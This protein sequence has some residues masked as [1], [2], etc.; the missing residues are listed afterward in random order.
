MI[1]IVHSQRDVGIALFAGS[2]AGSMAS[3]SAGGHVQ[4][5]PPSPPGHD[6]RTSSIQALRM[7]AKEHVESITKG[8]QMV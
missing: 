1:A 6:P 7:R 4:P 8:L 5:P 2:L 3:I